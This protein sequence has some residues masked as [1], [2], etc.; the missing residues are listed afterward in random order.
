MFVLIHFHILCE[1]RAYIYEKVV[2]CFYDF[3]KGREFVFR[4]LL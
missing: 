4:L 2:K 3:F 1:I